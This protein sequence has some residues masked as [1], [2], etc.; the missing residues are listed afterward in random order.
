MVK[1]KFKVFK[2]I[3]IAL[4][5]ILFSLAN[6]FLIK[7]L[8][9]EGEEEP[10]DSIPGV[11]IVDVEKVISDLK[12]EHEEL[13]YESRDIPEFTSLVFKEEGQIKS[14][15]IDSNTGIELKL[16]YIS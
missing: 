5:V 1:V 13:L 7:G 12:G 9:M 4:I 2:I 15:I 3:F 16:E 11:P 6:F 10:V 14:Y 8:L